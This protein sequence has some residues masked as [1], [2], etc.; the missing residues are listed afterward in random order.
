MYSCKQPYPAC[1]E[2]AAS[3]SQTHPAKQKKRCQSGSHGNH[4]HNP[5][6]QDVSQLIPMPLTHTPCIPV[7][8]SQITLCHTHVTTVS[9][10]HSR[11]LMA[12]IPPSATAY[13][14]KQVMAVCSLI[15]HQMPALPGP[16][17]GPDHLHHH[18]LGAQPL[19]LPAA[20]H[21]VGMSA[22]MASAPSFTHPPRP[23][24][25]GPPALAWWPA[26]VT[27]WRVRPLVH[28]CSWPGSGP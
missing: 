24:A 12:H 16:G 14:R 6:E 22:C 18:R 27:R 19:L 4:M 26:L 28:P 13:R 10:S 20:V 3:K 17:P 15:N 7:V 9:A 11:N 8:P 2:N 21:C 23:D 25:A 1:L 5:T